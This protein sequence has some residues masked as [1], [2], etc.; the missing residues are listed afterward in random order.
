MSV[1]PSTVGEMDTRPGGEGPH[2]PEQKLCPVCRSTLLSRYNKDAVC[3]MCLRDLRRSPAG[4]PMWLWDSPLMRRALAD[5]NFSWVLA[6]FRSAAGLTQQQLADLV[7]GWTKTKVTRAESGERGTLYDIREL[8]N[9]ADAICMPREALM[10]LI[11]GTPDA[12]P[13]PYVGRESGEMNRRTFNGS[14]VLF[15]TSTLLPDCFVPPSSI[16]RS[17]VRYLETCVDQLWTADWAVGGANLIRQA[18]RL[19]DRAKA[20]LDESDYSD[21]TGLDLVRVGADLANCT[22]FLAFDA[23]EL[24]LARGL[25]QE[26]AMLADGGDDSAL[27]AHIYATMAMQST[28]LARVSGQRGPAREAMRALR[29]AAQASKH[30]PSP[31]LHAL[32]AMRSATASA[33]LGD[34]AGARASIVEAHHELD[35]GDHPEDRQA[36]GFVDRSE[37]RGHEARVAALLGDRAAAAALLQR[38]LNDKELAPRNR[39]YYQATL[40]ENWLADGHVDAALDIGRQVLGDLA[41]VGSVRTLN[42]LQPLTRHDPAFH[43]RYRVVADGLSTKVTS[44]P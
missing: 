27:R 42:A 25:S 12:A 36:F 7:P 30:V 8:L 28:A 43:D 44:L 13:E 33:L 23:G 22:S 14:L 18:L 3:S 17:H 4:A 34:P 35:R 10:P 5:L 39:V 32:I 41:V 24:V 21:R 9:L 40:A 37:V 15:T 20:M 1:T 38:V 16:S 19:F 6:L 31:K 26:A 29:V 11:L 2:M